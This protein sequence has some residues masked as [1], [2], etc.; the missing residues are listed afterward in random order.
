MMK[1]LLFLF[2]FIADQTF[3]QVNIAD[4]FVL[5]YEGRY[6]LYGTDDK[7][8]NAGIPVLVS[9]DMVN[10]SGPAGKAEGKLALAKGGSYGTKGFWAPFV[11]NYKNRFY[12]YYTANEKIA[13]A[14]SESPLGPFVQK[15]FRPMQDSIKEIDPSVFI[16]DNGKKYI[17]FARLIKGNRTY[18]AELN[19]DM[20]SVKKETIVECI[21]YSQPWE[22]VS[23]SEWPV[24]EA[25]SMLKHQGKYYLF[26]TAN[27]FRSP[28][29]NVGYAVSDSPLGPFI[30]YKQNPLIKQT[31]NIKGTGGCEFVINGSNEII[32]FYHAH[33]NEQ[34]ATPRRTLFSK[35]MFVPGDAPGQVKFQVSGNK[36]FAG[37]VP[38]SN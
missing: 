31:D 9:D 29:Y 22:V 19:D 23:G 38:S 25:P 12:M 15:E 5:H 27:D 11:I 37:F 16:D 32:M 34:A 17:Y 3:A 1:N 26:Y 10:W 21:S 13:V 7:K 33:A 2:L 30:K 35:T 24:T 28:A 20:L 18:A 6:Y 14:T 4:P 36:V 8:P